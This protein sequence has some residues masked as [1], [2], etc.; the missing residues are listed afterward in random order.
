LLTGIELPA[1]TAIKRTIRWRL[2]SNPIALLLVI[3]YLRIFSFSSG[4]FLPNKT[5]WDTFL[6][7]EKIEGIGEVEVAGWR[8]G[9]RRVAKWKSQGG[10]V[11]VAGEW[12]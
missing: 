12:V 9:S 1:A 4:V 7:R 10:E 8:S 6:G 5:V 3:E 2:F 11:E